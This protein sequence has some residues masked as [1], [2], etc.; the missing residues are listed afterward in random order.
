MFEVI[1]LHCWKYRNLL[2]GYDMFTATMQDKRSSLF[3]YYQSTE[4]VPNVE[5]IL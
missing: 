1:E 4:Q 3:E 2:Y 5:Y